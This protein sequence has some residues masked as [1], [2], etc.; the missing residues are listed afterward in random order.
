[1]GSNKI[2]RVARPAPSRILVAWSLLS[3]GLVCLS[4]VTAQSGGDL[5]DT[6]G[7]KAAV[8]KALAQKPLRWGKGFQALLWRN[9]GPALSKDM[10]AVLQRIGVTG[11]VVDQDEDPGPIVK[12]GFPFYLDHAAGK[13]ILHLRAKDFDPVRKNYERKRTWEVLERPYPLLLPATRQKML[14]LLNTRVKR[15][16]KYGPLMISLDDEISVTRLANPLDFCFHES[17]LAGFRTWLRARYGTVQRLSRIWGRDIESFDKVRPPT[18][19]EVRDRELHGAGLPQSLA[20]W[21]DFR[22]FMD[23]CLAGTLG[24]LTESSRRLAPGVPVGFE[25]GQAPAAFGG[26]N[27]PLLLQK[28]DFV[29]PY[30]IGGTRELVLSLKKPGTLHYET[31]F[32]ERRVEMLPRVQA[33]IYDA[34]GH[35]LD[36]LILWSS[37]LIF[38]GKTKKRLSAY[39]RTLARELR[40]VTSDQAAPLCHA[41]LEKG[42]IAIYE[43]QRNVRLLWM[44]DSARD[45][46]TWTRRFGSYEKD[47]STSQAGRLSWIRLLQDLGFPPRFLTPESLLTRG[48]RGSGIRAL[49]LRSTLSL[50][51]EEA[52]AML[53]FVR[54]GG[55]LIAD[56]RPGIYDENLNLRSKGILDMLFGVQ[57]DGG[58]RRRVREGR[59]LAGTPRLP[60]KLS[61]AEVGLIPVMRTPHQRVGKDSCAFERPDGKGRVVLL[62]MV[63]HEYWA[64]RLDAR[65]VDRC[66]DLRGRIKRVLRLMELVPN[67]AIEVR[68]YPTILEKRW[69]KLKSGERVLY[70][71]PNC[72]ESE[73]LFLRLVKSGPVPM[74]IH[75]PFAGEVSDFWTGRVLGRGRNVSAKLDPIRGSFL[76]VKRL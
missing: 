70:V 61:L 19:D 49:V 44:L 43:S 45:G 15:A 2:M 71:H 5:S 67:V 34:L 50:S 57:A 33:R 7:D 17:S 46:L 53:T 30:D 14:D 65:N 21:N 68:G 37:G 28:V 36:G 1:M 59:A 24:Q 11:V 23:I 18:T 48:L 73:E 6:Q 76:R 54:A 32:P 31:I 26:W 75:L 20:D 13:G 25:G 4:G 16:A 3:L 9:E 40:I 58:S 66:R 64:D 35:G 55:L 41:T 8:Q 22:E 60:S 10:V 52:R 38:E 42:P 51:A 74:R 39:G 47:H 69:L 27:W 72:M 56:E 29:E 12:M 63:T 62:N